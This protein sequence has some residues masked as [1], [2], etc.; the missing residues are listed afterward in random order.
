MGE[1]RGGEP[2]RHARWADRHARAHSS[3]RSSGEPAAVRAV[4]WCAACA[5]WMPPDCNLSAKTLRAAPSAGG[6]AA[7]TPAGSRAGTPRASG[8]AQQAQPQPPSRASSR[9]GGGDGSL[10]GGAVFGSHAWEAA[11]TATYALRPSSFPPTRT[12]SRGAGAAAA[13]A[14]QAQRAATAGHVGGQRRPLAANREQPH[15]AGRPAAGSSKLGS[16]QGS[17]RTTPFAPRPN[18]GSSRGGAAGAWRCQQ[19]AHT[20]GRRP[21]GNPLYDASS[22]LPLSLDGLLHYGGPGSSALADMHSAPGSS[23][24]YDGSSGLEAAAA[25]SH[26]LQ[27]GDALAWAA[28]HLAG[29]VD[30]VAAAA[31]AVAAAPGGDCGPLDDLLLAV[32]RMLRQVERAID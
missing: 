2:A 7:S 26:P 11:E 20:K 10:A 17:A 6:S 21:R 4:P 28:R 27:E 3:A 23:R 25:A 8:A 1:R 31:E 16:R 24:A 32:D 19:Q 30:S 13:A 29:S 12:T 5:E 14:G 9:L 18:S 15:A 22:L